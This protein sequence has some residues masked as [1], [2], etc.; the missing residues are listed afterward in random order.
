MDIG[1]VYRQYRSIPNFDTP[2][3]GPSILVVDRELI[4]FEKIVI[5][6]EKV[7]FTF[8]EVTNLFFVGDNIDS[9]TMLVVSV[10]ILSKRNAY[11]PTRQ[12]LSIFIRG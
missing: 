1:D 9:T 5:L 4:A 11:I 6:H 10:L 2:I 8:V 12:R 3:Y 7:V